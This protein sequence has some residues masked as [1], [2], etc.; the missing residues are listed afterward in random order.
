L[1]KPFDV[2]DRPTTTSL[3]FE[4]FSM[5]PDTM[6]ALVTVGDGSC[7]LQDVKIPSLGADQILVKVV[8]AAQ[9]PTDCMDDLFCFCTT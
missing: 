7:Q 9:N 2:L 5:V 8:A 4:V 6:K 3:N 1:P